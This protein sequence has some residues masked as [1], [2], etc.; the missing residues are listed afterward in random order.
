MKINQLISRPKLK[1]SEIGHD[2]STIRIFA[3][4]K[5]KRSQCPVCVRY[6]SFV[7]DSYTRTISVLLVFQLKTLILLKIRKFKCKNIHC[8]QKVFSEHGI[9]TTRYSKNTIQVSDVLDL[10]SIELMGKLGSLLSK[11]LFKS[12]SPATI[13]RRAHQQTLPQIKQPMVLGVDDWAF[14]KGVNYGTVLIDMETSKPIDLLSSRE[15]S[16]LK[17][18]LKKYQ[19]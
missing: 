4:L 7:H 2:N 13:T 8:K 3:S 9:Y 15:S 10:M 12:I 19:R 18:W 16:D 1:I 14:R 11:K 17:E 5:S 6:S